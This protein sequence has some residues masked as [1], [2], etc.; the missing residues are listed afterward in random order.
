M[1]SVVV[2]IDL[3]PPKR[4]PEPIIHVLAA[5]SQLLRIYRPEPFGQTPTGFRA[6]G[7]I[8]RFDHHNKNCS[9][10]ILYVAHSLSC[11]LAECFG[12]TGL[13]EFEG[14][15][16]ALLLTLRPLRLLDLR[17]NGAMRAGSVAALASCADRTISQAWSRH[18]Y[19]T[20]PEIDGLIYSSAHNEEAA[21]ALYERADQAIRCELDLPLVHR[22]L[23]GRIIAA[24]LDQAMILSGH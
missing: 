17:R 9:H 7:P 18:F 11:C 5:G 13:I 20:Y 2:R 19:Q 1:P 16:L 21:L 23:R 22:S 3:P 15:R 24:A 10:G 4:T 14:R 8:E 12:D 6:A